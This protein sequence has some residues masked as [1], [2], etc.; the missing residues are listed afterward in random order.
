MKR[1]TP[2]LDA[3][4]AFLQAADTASFREAADTLAIS[5][6]AFSR[7]IQALEDFLGTSLFDRSGS[8]VVLNATGR[9]Y[10]RAIAAL[11][12]AIRKAST[13]G[14][15]RAGSLRI[16]APHSFTRGPGS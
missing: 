1:Q 9:E 4:E 16:M 6:P 12:D 14:T 10:L 2:P 7:R 5:A 3:I 13:P 15:G 11:I 8:R